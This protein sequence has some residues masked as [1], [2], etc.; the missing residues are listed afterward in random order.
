MRILII[1]QGLAGTLASHACLQRG[2]DVHVMDSGAPS[3]S[4][5]AAGMYNP[6]SFRRIVEVWDAEAHWT[7][8]QATYADLEALLGVQ[9]LHPLPIHKHIPNEEYAALWDSKAPHIRWISPVQRLSNGR[10]VG[11]VDGGGWVNVTLLLDQWRAKLQAEGRF[12]TDSW[13]FDGSG[14]A[15]DALIDCRG[16][17]ARHDVALGP[18]DIRANRGEILTIEALDSSIPPD[19]IDNFGKWTLPVAPDMWRLGASY[20]WHRL[21]LD[22]TPE[23]RDILVSRLKDI[24]PQMHKVEVLL[25]QAGLRPVSKDRRPAVGPMPSHPNHFVFNGLGTRGVLI[26]PRWAQHLVNGIAGDAPWDPVVDPARLQMD[27]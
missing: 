8:M 23:T 24:H 22:P 2:W 25:H 14:E 4:R 19:L 16:T 3:A 5:V 13:A 17:A 21:D 1:G 9:L 6:M 12:S 26:G 15:W 20:E 7:A 18:L 10:T 27:A 11:R